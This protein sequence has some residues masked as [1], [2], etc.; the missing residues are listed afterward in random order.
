MAS[1]SMLSSWNAPSTLRANSSTSDSSR[2]SVASPGDQVRVASLAC[3]IS[4]TK[5]AL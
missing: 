5:R 2:R 3:S 1:P 4:F